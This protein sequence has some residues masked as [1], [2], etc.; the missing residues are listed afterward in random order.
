[1]LR[2]IFLRTDINC[3]I[4]KHFMYSRIF[5]SMSNILYINTAIIAVIIRHLVL[6]SIALNVSCR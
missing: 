1:M 6:L 2:S 4:T 3:T 5:W